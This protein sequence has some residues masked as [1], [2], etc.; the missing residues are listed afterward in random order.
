MT[1]WEKEA[2]RMI[3]EYAACRSTSEKIMYVEALGD[4]GTDLAVLEEV[5]R[6]AV[7]GA[8]SIGTEQD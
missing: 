8:V 1:Q 3:L 4:R 7:V 5:L 2:R 6:L